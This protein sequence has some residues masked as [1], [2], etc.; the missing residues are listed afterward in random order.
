MAKPYDG[1]SI[2]VISIVNLNNTRPAVANESSSRTIRWFASLNSR[3][4]PLIFPET[5]E[6]SMQVVDPDTRIQPMLS[7]FKNDP[8]K[9][10]NT[11]LLTQW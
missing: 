9:L 10:L 6:D 7:K 1:K 3:R 2:Q 8:E 5:E 11:F 4:D